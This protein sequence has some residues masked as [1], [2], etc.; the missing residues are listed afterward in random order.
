MTTA[1]ELLDRIDAC[2]DDDP[3]QAAQWLRTLEPSALGAARRASLA[4]LIN[5]VL[6]EKLAQWP[7]ALL[8]QESLLAL[9]PGSPVL[10][11]QA[12]A[13]A[14]SAGEAARA[15]A[16]VDALAAAT[17]S[18]PRQAA[19]L[20]ELAATLFALPSLDARAAGERSLSALRVL[21]EAMWRSA[22]PL[23]TAAATAC[24]NIASGF[25][26]RPAAD[27]AQATLRAALARGNAG[28]G[29]R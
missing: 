22:G 27:L 4:F 3:A 17:Q 9:E 10:L 25:V 11:R 15:A 1:D 16:L 18:D 19:Q 26:E 5:H 21:D 28:R 8:R 2:P 12:A 20:V 13:A 14:L 6:G 24:N 23:D 7:E 29:L